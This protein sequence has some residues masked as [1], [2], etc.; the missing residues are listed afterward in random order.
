[1]IAVERVKRENLLLARG[2]I[3]IITAIRLVVAEWG[4][5]IESSSAV[6][7]SG[8]SFGSGPKKGPNTSPGRLVGK[9]TNGNPDR[10]R[11]V[12]PITPA[13]TGVGKHGSGK[14]ALNQ[15]PVGAAGRQAITTVA[16]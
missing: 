3:A 16:N 15:Q 4:R 12:L 14:A 9:E 10:N 1:M 2:W 8:W 5:R 6:A 13:E 11:W 7:G